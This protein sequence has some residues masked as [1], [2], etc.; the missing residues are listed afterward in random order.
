TCTSRTVAITY[1]IDVL[2][3]SHYRNLRT[4]TSFTGDRFNLYD[5]IIDFSN[6]C[7]EHTAQESRMRSGNKD[8]WPACRT[9]HFGDINFDAVMRLIRFVRHLCRLRHNSFNFAEANVQIA[10]IHPFNN[11]VDDVIGAVNEFFEY[12]T[13]FRFTDTLRNNLL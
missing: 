6:F 12:Q 8:L 11:T 5:A 3:M 7:F 10:C 1:R 9:L 2:T 13:A 4:I